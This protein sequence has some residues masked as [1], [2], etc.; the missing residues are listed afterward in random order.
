[1]TKIDVRLNSV[2]YSKTFEYLATILEGVID[3][4]TPF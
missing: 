3:M 4:E 1:M 2:K